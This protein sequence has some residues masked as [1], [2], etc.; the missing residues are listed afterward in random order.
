MGFGGP[1]DLAYHRSALLSDARG[2]RARGIRSGARS[3]RWAFPLLVLVL[4]SA[5]LSPARAA[6]PIQR[7]EVRL[8]IEGGDPHPLIIRRIV[9]AI[10]ITAERLLVGRDSELVGRQEAALTGVLREVVDRVVRGYRVTALSFQPGVTTAVLVRLQA[11]LP[12]LSEVPVVTVLDAVH[13]DAQPLVRAVLEPAIPDLQGLLLRLPVESLE[14][15][16]AIVERR[17]TEVVEGAAVGFTAT[18]RVETAP[19]ARIVVSVVARDSRVIRDIGVRFRSASIPFVLTN[20]HA[21]Q[22]VSMAE[23]LRGLPVAFALAQRTRLEAMIRER[24]AA[25]PPVRQY[26]IVA[27]PVLQVGEVTY[28]TVLAESTLYRGRV[29]AR[30]NFGSQAPP[31]DVRL[32]LGRALGSFEPY[33]E[34]TLV[35]ST[36]S[37][38]WAVGLRLQVGSHATI[39]IKTG[40]AGDDQETFLTYRLSPDLHL[41]G[42]YLPRIDVIETTLSHRVNEV[43]SWEAVATSRGMVWVR[44]VGNL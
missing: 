29:E 18:G 11:R 27:Q 24:L 37:L 25:Y 8:T 10:G 21:P 41:R 1:A 39:G 22:V 13:P 32:Q 28:V 23:P 30:I 14:W 17:T 42:A 16:A 34:L 6:D 3:A 26:G 15:A 38:R 31:T 20:Q 35:P 12:I 44:L 9:D 36:L 4:V 19:A 5:T 2:R 7:V 43:F 33:M 40:F